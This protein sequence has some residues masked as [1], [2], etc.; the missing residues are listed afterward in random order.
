MLVMLIVGL[1][2]LV[3][4]LFSAKFV[5]V[6][7]MAKLAALAMYMKV[8][9]LP[10][11]YITLAR[12]SSRSYLF[13]E[14]TYYVVLVLLIIFGY[15]HWG[16]IGTGLALVL[17]HIFDLLL[18]W[19]YAVI[20]YHYRVSATVVRYAALQTLLGVATYLLTTTLP[21]T[22]WLYWVG[23]TVFFALSFGFSFFII[24]S[25]TSLWHSLKNKFLNR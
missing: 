8:I 11:A 7:P 22:D 25:K 6:V 13:L 14:T 12:G 23:G 9:T 21:Y 5:T 3:P 4:L 17:A 24:R 16:I 10:V 18:I 19:T 20:V 2:L 15:S 1:P